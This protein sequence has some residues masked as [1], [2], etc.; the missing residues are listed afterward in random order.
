VRRRPTSQVHSREHLETG[1]FLLP[2]AAS[3]AD[4]GSLSEP[5]LSLSVSRQRSSGF[6][7]GSNI[8][9]TL[10][11]P[12]PTGSSSESSLCFRLLLIIDR[13]E[14]IAILVT[15]VEKADLP[16]KVPRCVKAPHPRILEN[17]L[18]V[19][20]VSCNPQNGPKYHFAM[21]PAKLEIG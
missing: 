20:H 16:S 10:R 7:A 19:I 2:F 4:A 18:C 21:S 14:L 13:A 12:G 3:K 11:L 15:Q 9:M 1:G 5:A 17:V 6:R 8:S